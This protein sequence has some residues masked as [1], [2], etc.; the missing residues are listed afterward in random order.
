MVWVLW[1]GASRARCVVTPDQ[2]VSRETSDQ[3]FQALLA[4]LREA[5]DEAALEFVERYAPHV[6]RAVRRLLD[7]RLR[8]KLDS[9]D[10]VQSVWHSFFR[11][12]TNLKRFDRAA[13]L[14]GFL[15]KL[16]EHKVAEHAR[17]YLRA[18]RDIRR[19]QSLAETLAAGKEALPC[20]THTP[21]RIAAAREQIARLLRGQPESHQEILC[22]RATGETIEAIAKA[23]G[24]HERT[25][26]KILEHSKCWR[27]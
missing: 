18:K 6:L 3:E 4:R 9:Q 12:P 5:D 22:R 8:C 15:A 26:Y 21:N 2:A 7:R 19:E 10:I 1:Q 20:D 17:R 25:I 14:V 24:L 13:Q 23:L 27:A 11:H 16:A